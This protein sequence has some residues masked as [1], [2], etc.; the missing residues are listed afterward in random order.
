MN[1]KSENILNEGKKSKHKQNMLPVSETFCHKKAKKAK[2]FAIALESRAQHI[3][4]FG[5][6]PDRSPTRAERLAN[7]GRHDEKRNH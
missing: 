7:R 2:Y 4:L 3:L 5:L 1:Q 6:E